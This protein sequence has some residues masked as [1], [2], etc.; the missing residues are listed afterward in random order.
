MLVS[1]VKFILL[2]RNCHTQ[3]FNFSH[4]EM[5][6]SAQAKFVSSHH[7][8]EDWNTRVLCV[9]PSQLNV[10]RFI[11]SGFKQVGVNSGKKI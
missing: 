6:S 5:P 4:G 1:H 7:E 3:F 8:T 11:W 9:P 2:E 10:E